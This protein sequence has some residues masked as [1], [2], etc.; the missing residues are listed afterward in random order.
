MRL[1]RFGAA[2][3]ALSFAVVGGGGEATAQPAACVDLCRVRCVKPISIADRW[4]D[5]TGI[6]GYMGELAGRNRRPPGTRMATSR[7]AL[8]S[9]RSD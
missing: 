2:M 4:D 9:T 5:V 6:P 7:V 3:I 1:R 8:R